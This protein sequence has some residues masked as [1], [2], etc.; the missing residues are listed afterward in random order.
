M[1]RSGG[2]RGG[3]MALQKGMRYL[4]LCL[5]VAVLSAAAGYWASGLKIAAALTG[6]AVM[7][8]GIGVKLGVNRFYRFKRGRNAAVSPKGQDRGDLLR[9]LFKVVAEMV[10]LLRS[11]EHRPVMGAQA[12]QWEQGVLRYSYV[13]HLLARHLIVHPEWATELESQLA[14]VYGCPAYMIPVVERFIS[15]KEACE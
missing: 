9:D 5:A 14:A 7:V 3:D 10:E 8:L 1:H 2:S 11:G 13:L 4:R 15:E 12:E 6:I